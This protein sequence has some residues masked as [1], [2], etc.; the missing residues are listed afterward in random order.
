MVASNLFNLY[1]NVLD[2]LRRIGYRGDLLAEHYRF[3]DWFS[4]KT[5]ERF[6]RSRRVRPDAGFLRLCVY[7]SGAKPTALAAKSL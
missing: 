6:C 5:E 2:G 1:D 3:A 4:L 7:R